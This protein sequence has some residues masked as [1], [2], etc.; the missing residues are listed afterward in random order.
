MAFFGNYEISFYGI[1]GHLLQFFYRENWL[2]WGKCLF[3]Y[4]HSAFLTGCCTL[5]HFPDK[6]LPWP[7]MI[8]SD[9]YRD[10]WWVYSPIWALASVKCRPSPSGQVLRCYPSISQ[11]KYDP[12]A[13]WNAILSPEFWSSSFSWQTHT[14]RVF[15]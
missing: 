2:N 11:T 3:L 12:S 8:F 6:S 5:H 7:W 9:I 4:I 13:S 1:T 15:N 10:D 14:I